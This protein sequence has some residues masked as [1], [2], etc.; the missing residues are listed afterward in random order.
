MITIEIKHDFEEKDIAD[1]LCSA[2]EGISRNW[3]EFPISSKNKKPV[4]FNNT[5]EGDEKYTHISYPMNEGGEIIV[6]DTEGYGK[7][8]EYTLN[9]VKIRRGLKRMARS[10]EY[11]FRFQNI[12]KGDYDTIDA[13]VF[14]Q[15]AVLGEVLYS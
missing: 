15:F 1:L 6:V 12:V 3:A 14:L 8:T 13:D 5:K 10:K 2:I 4:N 11:A 9:L 7:N